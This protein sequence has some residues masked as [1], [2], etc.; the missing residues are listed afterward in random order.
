MA[1]QYW[2]I[3]FQITHSLVSVNSDLKIEIKTQGFRDRIGPH[4][5]TKKE[6]TYSVQHNRQRYSETLG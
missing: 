4:L 6:N 5:W 1:Y 3:T 2:N